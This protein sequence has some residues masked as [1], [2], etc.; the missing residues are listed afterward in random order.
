MWLSY[1]AFTQYKRCPQQYNYQRVKKIQPTKPESKHNAI[2]GSVV[3]R[4]FED[5]YNNELWRKGED[6]L[7]TLLL[8]T[9]RYFWEY[10]SQNHVDFDDPLCRF[11]NANEALDECLDLIPKSLSAIKREKLLGPYAKSEIK[12]EVRL[13]DDD[14]LFGFIDFMIRKS[15]GTILLVDGKA[16]KKREKYVDEDQLHFYSLLFYY[17]YERRLPDK[18]GFLFYSFGDIPDLAVEWLIPDKEKMKSLRDD[19]VKV[20]DNIKNREYKATPSTFACRYCPYEDICLE[21]KNQKNANKMK[22]IA[23]STKDTPDLDIDE[24][25][26]FLGF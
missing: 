8:L 23:N 12:M 18:L 15:D 16:S 1:S 22:R 3:Q 2:V 26:G 13:R 19:I 20:I 7:D 17:R 6:T 4:V 25:T 10:L 9:D 21:R 11:K 24:D 5:F 14:F